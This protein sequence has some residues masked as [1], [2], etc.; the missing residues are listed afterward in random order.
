MAGQGAPKAEAFARK[1]L[2]PAAAKTRKSPGKN[3]T[4]CVG[5][6]SG[7]G[8]SAQTPPN[9]NNKNT[10]EKPERET[11]SNR[12]AKKSPRQQLQ[13][14]SQK[15]CCKSYKY[16]CS[17]HRNQNYSHNYSQNHNCNHKYNYYN[18]YNNYKKYNIHSSYNYTGNC[19][20][21]NY[22]SN[23]NKQKYPPP[24]LSTF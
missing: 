21:Q 19:N 20:K 5:P 11:I 18:Y 24:S 17:C 4:P 3:E 16:N 22:T 8:P 6:K 10:K 9:K 12:R 2:A 13:L 23:Y 14:Q 7:E 1:V 15:K